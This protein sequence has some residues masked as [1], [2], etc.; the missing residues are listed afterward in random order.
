MVSTDHYLLQIDRPSRKVL[1]RHSI[2][3]TIFSCLEKTLQHL[4]RVCSNIESPIKN[5]VRP[6]INF[7]MLCG[8]NSLKSQWL[9][10]HSEKSDSR[11]L[12]A[13]VQFW[14]VVPLWNPSLTGENSSVRQKTGSYPVPSKSLETR[15]K[16]IIGQGSPQPLNGRSRAHRIHN[17][18]CQ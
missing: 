10:C 17:Q 5:S 11:G 6:A 4:K 9:G 1:L 8:V 2:M 13:W 14:A 7:I 12:V 18:I 3:L 16:S 15:T